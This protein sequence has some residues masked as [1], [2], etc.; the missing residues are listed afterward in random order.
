MSTLQ[1]DY[2]SSDAQGRPREIGSE[3]P[4]GVEPG[5]L[6]IAGPLDGL[7]IALIGPND[8]SRNDMA[9]ALVASGCKDIHA[10]SSYP[11]SLDDTPLLLMETHNLVI[12]ELDTDAEYAVRLVA[13]MVAAGTP[14][15]TVMVY[16]EK[17]VPDLLLRCMRAGAREF[18]VPPFGS[19]SLTDALTRAASRQAAEI[20]TIDQAEAEA[21]A[22]AATG[23]LLTFMGAKGGTGVTT[24]ACNFAVAL[25]QDP[26]QRTLLIDLDLPLGDVA[27]NLGISPEYS[28]INALQSVERLDSSLLESF[29]TR[30][31]SGLFV[32]S[33]PGRLSL[34]QSARADVNTLLT[35]AQQ[36]YE[37]IVVDIGTRLDLMETVLFQ[38]AHAVYLVTQA[39]IPELRNSNRLISQFFGDTGS[40]KLEVI[41]NRYEERAFGVSE[42][43]ITRALTR[44]AQWKVP[45]DYN[46]VRQMQIN[47]TP[48]ALANSPVSRE[49]R[50]IAKSLNSEVEVQEKKRVFSLFG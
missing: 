15:A 49:I 26:K 4:G 46:T 36:T 18:L 28:T 19:Q 50:R 17:T 8:E 12:I 27:L 31:G 23:R 43:E 24:L 45:N 13:C 22:K 16:S 38:K 11:P 2:D 37:N 20:A 3:R 9:K 34:Y 14:T 5:P 44:P 42:S 6:L 7:A 33:A 39:G 29:V 25:S 47:A 32:L 10:F 41:I 30:H 48:L 1:I 35:V 21:E 40:P